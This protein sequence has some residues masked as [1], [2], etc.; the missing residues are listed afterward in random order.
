TT[1]DAK[2]A[3]TW[4]GAIPYFSGRYVVDILGK[5][6][7]VIAHMEMRKPKADDNKWTFFLPGHLKYDYRHSIGELKPDAVLQFWGDLDEANEYMAGKYIKL[8]AGDKFIFLRTDSD[9]VLWSKFMQ[10]QQ[11][12]PQ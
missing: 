12:P 11:A 10:N 5:T 2:I 7:K 4:A 3:V 6:D 8:M 1:P 9:K